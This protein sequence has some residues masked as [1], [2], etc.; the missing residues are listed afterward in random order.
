MEKK[1]TNEVEKS[2]SSPSLVY[3]GEVTIT[4]KKN[5][6]RKTIKKHN[7]GNIGLETCIIRALSNIDVFNYT[8]SLLMGYYMDGSIE[9]PALIQN[10]SISSQPITYKD[11]VKS[12]ATE[13][14]SVQFSFLIP[15][16]SITSSVDITRLKLLNRNNQVCAQVD[17]EQ[18]QAIPSDTLDNIVIY[19]KMTFNAED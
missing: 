11:G 16:G 17:L 2:I 7:S 3:K 13:C 9:Q 19:W 8:P 15:Y 4:Y 14:D 5:N 18:S 6:K 10:I 1:K 12:D